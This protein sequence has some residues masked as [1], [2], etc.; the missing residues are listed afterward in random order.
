MLLAQNEVRATMQPGPEQLTGDLLELFEAGQHPHHFVSTEQSR[1]HDPADLEEVVNFGGTQMRAAMALRSRCRRQPWRHWC[2]G[3]LIA[4]GACQR[5]D[6][7]SP[8]RGRQRTPS[9]FRED[10]ARDL[11]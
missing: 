10:T 7:H 6:A 3:L 8:Y 9:Q 1:A 4:N 5:D 2:H 11:I